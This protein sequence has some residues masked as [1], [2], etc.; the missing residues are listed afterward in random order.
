M[1]KFA[2]LSEQNVQNTRSDQ[3]LLKDFE[4]KELSQQKYHKLA[5]FSTPQISENTATRAGQEEL[6]WGPPACSAALS[7]CRGL[8]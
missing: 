8:A 2:A 1:T 7:E 4:S 5:Q 6:Y 3:L